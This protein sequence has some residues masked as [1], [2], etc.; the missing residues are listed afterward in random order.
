M[1]EADLA[2]SERLGDDIDFGASST[3]TSAA[4]LELQ[5]SSPLHQLR[6][7]HPGYDWPT[8]II[9]YAAGR[10]NPH[11]TPTAPRPSTYF[12]QS[13]VWQPTVPPQLPSSPSH[14][15]GHGNVNLQAGSSSTKLPPTL[16]SLPPLPSTAASI[17][18]SPTGRL[19]TDSSASTSDL[20]GSVTSASNSNSDRDRPS[21]ATSVSSSADSTFAAA[22]EP[23]SWPTTPQPL[24]HPTEPAYSMTL[25]DAPPALPSSPTSSQLQAQ[26]P[27]APRVRDQLTTSFLTPGS[28]ASVPSPASPDVLSFAHRRASE[29]AGSSSMT[30]GRTMRIA[31]P[32]PPA[33]AA[34]S[35]AFHRARFDNTHPTPSVLRP[36][37][38]SP[39]PS[40]AVHGYSVT[41]GSAGLLGHEG[42]SGS[43][44]APGASTPDVTTAAAAMRWAAS[45]HPSIAPLAL[46][47]P[48]H[49]L[50]DPMRGVTVSLPVD[51]SG[52]RTSADFSSAEEEDEDGHGS[53][54]A[55]RRWAAYAYNSRSSVGRSA[56]RA[57]RNVRKKAS[58]LGKGDGNTGDVGGSGSGDKASSTRRIWEKFTRDGRSEDK[59]RSKLASS[60]LEDEGETLAGDVLSSTTEGLEG[61]GN[62]SIG[63]SD[64][65]EKEPGS[66]EDDKDDEGGG[67]HIP[68]EPR[69]PPI[70]PPHS[71]PGPTDA[72]HPQQQSRLRVI[73]VA[74][75][76]ER[77]GGKPQASPRDKRSPVSSLATIEASPLPSPIDE[78]PSMIVSGDSTES[79]GSGDSEQTTTV[80]N[81]PP[82]EN[83]HHLQL[84]G[85][86]ASYP[87]MGSVTAPEQ[88]LRFEG[89]EESG[90]QVDYF[91]YGNALR[92]KAD[93]EHVLK[94]TGSSSSDQPTSESPS[95]SSISGRTDLSGS[96]TSSGSSRTGPTKVSGSDETK[97]ALESSVVSSLPTLGTITSSSPGQAWSVPNTPFH[98]GVLN[99]QTSSPLPSRS[100]PEDVGTP[101]TNLRNNQFL[102]VE[103]HVI[104]GRPESVASSVSQTVLPQSQ[105]MTDNAATSSQPLPDVSS[106]RSSNSS[107]VDLPFRGSQEYT[108]LRVSSTFA[109]PGGKGQGMPVVKPR[110]TLSRAQS[111]KTVGSSGSAMRVS[112]EEEEFVKLGY[113]VPP[114][115]KDEEIRR[116]A[117]HKFNI[118]HTTPDVNFDRIAYLTK[119][120]FSTKI[121]VVSLVDGTEEWYK[122][123]CRFK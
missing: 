102:G 20:S 117:L 92:S 29:S 123:E 67:L 109:A 84:A 27:E 74:P 99:R 18:P 17:A 81:K 75:P 88:M 78:R 56:G 42:P 28:P 106:K 86:S 34:S 8:F 32:P 26:A 33:S 119:L 98:K 44:Q 72:V 91:G 9:A 85:R 105:G 59:R 122:M 5:T 50:M 37:I 52:R 30:S 57:V 54:G 22:V 64:E 38:L 107:V 82:R 11:R 43:G 90:Q 65:T 79:N 55:K 93:N 95:T 1:I 6:T 25:R 114:Y 70:Q 115:P 68:S 69:Q 47:S 104:P 49:E 71:Q 40:P 110:P 103:G 23:E 24:A 16:S 15:E 112:H 111:M 39:L 2:T 113:L 100:D 3:L 66:L 35:V 19:G 48:E 87:K 89:G 96:Q 77:E 63:G 21:S 13:S 97:T 73:A 83:R 51:A 120:V 61:E 108:H 118:M 53:S 10:W 12:T 80:N 46:P 14:L 60:S 45:S 101:S 76:G 62:G 7:E 4:T 121:V 36:P 58:L 116:R 94:E 31:M 41:V